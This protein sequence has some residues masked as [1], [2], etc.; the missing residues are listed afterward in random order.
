[1]NVEVGIDKSVPAKALITPSPT[2]SS[3]HSD[4]YGDEM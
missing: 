2:S 3:E 1:M 4:G